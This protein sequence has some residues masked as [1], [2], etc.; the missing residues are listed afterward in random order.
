[1]SVR[2]VKAVADVPAIDGDH[3]LA[4]VTHGKFTFG[5]QGLTVL[6]QPTFDEWA[7]AMHVLAVMER[8]LAF[9]IG[10][11]I[12]FGESAYGELAAQIIDARH[13]QPSTVNVYVWMAK[14]IPPENRMLDRGLSVAHHLAVSRLP[15]SEQRVWLRRAIGNGEA[16]P[17][18]INRLK[19]AIKADA[20]QEPTAWLVL[21]TCASEKKRDALQKQLELDG[22]ACRSVTKRGV[23]KETA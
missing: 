11:M 6:G 21:V 12:L 8:G 17:W 4:P 3:A 9:L 7:E 10:D 5:S 22:Y 23:Q 18:S 14:Q 19:A 13:W 15:P 16:E 1:M 2:H 20:D